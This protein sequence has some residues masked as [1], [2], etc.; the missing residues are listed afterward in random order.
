MRVG[1]IDDRSRTGGKAEDGVSDQVSFYTMRRHQSMQDI[2][3]G[4]E[5]SRV[6]DGRG[7][8]LEHTIVDTMMRIDL[9]A[10]LRPGDKLTLQIDWAFQIRDH[11]AI[12]SRG[13]FEHFEETDTYVYTLSQ[14]FPRMAAYTDYMS[15]QHTQFLGRGEFTLEFGD[16]DVEITV[17]ADHVVSATGELVNASAVLTGE[18][19]RRLRQARDADK[20]VFIVTPEEAKE[21]ERDKASGERTWHFRAENVRDFAW[22]SSRKFIWDA[23]GYEQDAGE[24]PLVMAMSFY[25]NEGEPIWSQYST[26]AVVHTMDVYSRFSFPYPYP[27]S[28]SVNGWERGGHGV[29]DDH[30]QRLSTQAQQRGGKR[31]H[32]RRAPDGTYSRRT[33]HA[34]IGVII[35]EIGHIYFPMTVNS[36][37]REWTWMDEGINSLSRVP[38]GARVG[39]E[40]PE[41]RAAYRSSTRSP[42]YM[43]SENQVPIM[44]QSDSILQFG[45]NAY[46]KPAAALVVLRETVMGRELFDFAFKEYS[47]RWAF[48]RPTP[49]DFFRTM[50]DASAL[51][52]DWFWRGWFYTTDHVDVGISGIR[53]YQISSMDPNVENPLGKA[54]RDA[55]RPEHIEQR[56]NREE[57][58]KTRLE[59]IEGLADFYNEHDPFT[60]SN[61]DI[62]TYESYLEGL[63]PWERQ[64]LERA[65]EAGEYIY[66]IDFANVGGLLTPLPL[67]LDLADGSSERLDVPA[68]I[69][70]R[71]SELATKI[72]ILPQRLSGVE[73]DPAQQTADVDRS[74]NYFPQR[75][76]PT[77]L[78]LFKREETTRD[79]MKDMLTKLKAKAGGEEEG[80]AMPMATPSQ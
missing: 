53:E 41:P 7:K 60:A 23:M 62:N 79:L 3:Y 66:F 61:K 2:D 55:R 76:V 51:D 25:P 11:R 78:E 73:L 63:E 42:S 31:G 33:K 69:W 24:H 56:R 57:G 10:P 17:P 75:M 36:D 39:G 37:E 6:A 80:E 27:T 38:S 72:L 49:E 4:F 21:N 58:R 13:G 54:R 65:V 26:E 45:P 40:L 52:L 64:V 35:H 68:Q 50:E 32:G 44:T 77:R 29:S 46:T 18:Q 43:M 19:Q 28:Q 9:P 59:R 12:G 20:P 70:R 71:N 74:N 14:W 48:K 67:K 47:R 15:W 30:L 5:L 22:A 1:S 34:L 16:Y 8:A